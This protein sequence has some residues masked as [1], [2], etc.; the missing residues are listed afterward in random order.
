MLKRKSSLLEEI[1]E[2]GR[3]RMKQKKSF[4]V[5]I[6]YSIIRL[7]KFIFRRKEKVIPKIN[8]Q[9]FIRTSENSK[10]KKKKKP[11]IKKIKKTKKAI[12][13]KTKKGKKKNAIIKR[14]KS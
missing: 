1:M 7:L 8:V 11:S 2:N 10:V 9:T 6:L 3:I 13:K 14:S 5:G 12:P 4:T